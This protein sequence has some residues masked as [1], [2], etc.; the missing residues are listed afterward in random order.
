M[1][2]KGSTGLLKVDLSN[3]MNMYLVWA[4]NSFCSPKIIRDNL[5]FWWMCLLSRQTQVYAYIGLFTSTHSHRAEMLKWWFLERNSPQISR[6]PNY[7]QRSICLKVTARTADVWTVSCC[8]MCWAVL[9]LCANS[10]AWLFPPEILQSSSWK[11]KGIS[12][13]SRLP[14]N[15]NLLHRGLPD[16]LHGAD[17]HPVPH[18]EHHQEAWLQQPARCPQADKANPSAQTGNRK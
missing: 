8:S 14:G 17:G 11:G 15:S 13:I 9:V 5:I 10:A 7:P 3:T 18:E 16:C 6:W 4:L 1:W 2:L 12:N